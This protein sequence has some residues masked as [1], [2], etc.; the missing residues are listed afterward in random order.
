MSPG[1]P[2]TP[3]P[4]DNQEHLPYEGVITSDTTIMDEGNPK[5][6]AFQTVLGRLEH[7]IHVMLEVRRAYSEWFNE[8]APMDI[9][10]LTLY[11]AVEMNIPVSN[12]SPMA[13]YRFSLQERIRVQYFQ[14]WISAKFKE[15]TSSHIN[16]YP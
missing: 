16:I 9:S 14:E 1:K 3:K 12:F 5:L 11:V 15:L 10:T 6:T 2:D 4:L 13:A 8:D 7:P